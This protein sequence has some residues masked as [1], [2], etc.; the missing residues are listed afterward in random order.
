MPSRS[1]TAKRLSTTRFLDAGRGKMN[2]LEDVCGR[3][4]VG[5]VTC[6]IDDI[7]KDGDSAI[8]GSRVILR[9]CAAAASCTSLATTDG[10][11]GDKPSFLQLRRFAV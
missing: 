6:L 4:R 10:A 1:S 2:Q 9:N 3:R 8:P 5:G 11:T 7:F